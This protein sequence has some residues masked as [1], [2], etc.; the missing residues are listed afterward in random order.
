MRAIIILLLLAGACLLPRDAAAAGICDC[1][2]CTNCVMTFYFHGNLRCDTCRTIE[3]YTKETIETYFKDELRA[4][5]L[6][7]EVINT[8]IDKN[9]ID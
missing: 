8:D 7:F 6:C 1:C 2:D 4:N 9:E 3:R 5:E